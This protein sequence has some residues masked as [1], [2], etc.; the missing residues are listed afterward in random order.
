MGIAM[1]RVV[2][3]HLILIFFLVLN[4]NPLIAD[5]TEAVEL[6]PLIEESVEAEKS[7]EPAEDEI[8]EEESGEEEPNDKKDEKEPDSKPPTEAEIESQIEFLKAVVDGNIIRVE[9]IFEDEKVKI[10]IDGNESGN[11]LIKA[12]QMDY[13]DIVTYLIEN[14]AADWNKLCDAN[15][16]KILMDL[17]YKDKEL[18]NSFK[19]PQ[20][21]ALESLEV[22]VNE[23][24]V[25]PSQYDYDSTINT[26][27]FK[28]EFIPPEKAIIFVSY[29]PNT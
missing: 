28:P 17:G 15:F 20:I 18:K 23:H 4:L 19:L 3:I 13:L 10:N 21:P 1:K 5:E 7:E 22:K 14:K 27:I 25:P 2:N 11:P 16:N 26:I 6:T 8:T 24:A 29:L 9:R 12:V